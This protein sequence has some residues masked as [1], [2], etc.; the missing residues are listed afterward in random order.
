MRV[1]RR[2]LLQSYSDGMHCHDY[3]HQF[4]KCPWL[5]MDQMQ[6]PSRSRK[7]VQNLWISEGGSVMTKSRITKAK[8]TSST[9]PCGHLSSNN[10]C[11]K[12]DC[13]CT[14]YSRTV[15]TEQERRRF[16]ELC[17]LRMRTIPPESRAKFLIR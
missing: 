13:P 17:G 16:A 5:P 3:R 6:N 4:C 11:S 8:N 7:A 9:I 14:S 15:T 12:I 1:R 2:G 10:C